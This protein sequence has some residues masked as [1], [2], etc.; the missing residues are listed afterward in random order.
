MS[1]PRRVPAPRPP[2]DAC[3]GLGGSS[4]RS[5]P[6]C[7]P[8]WWRN[9]GVPTDGSRHA[10]ARSSSRCSP[11]RPQ[12]DTDSLRRSALPASPSPSRGA[13]QTRHWRAAPCSSARGCPS[14]CST[15][16][17]AM[18]P[19]A[20]SSATPK[21]PP[22]DTS[23][24]TATGQTRHRRRRAKHR[25]P[26]GRRTVDLDTP[27]PPVA[28]ASLLAMDAEDSH[29][30]RGA[31]AVTLA[32]APAPA[33]GAGSTSVCVR[34]DHATSRSGASVHSGLKP[35]PAWRA[36]RGRCDP[37]SVARP[38]RGSS[39]TAV[40]L[41]PCRRARPARRGHRSTPSGCARRARR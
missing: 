9:L 26:M 38:P 16:C 35:G 36:L 20:T 6:P 32:L 40:A 33:A 21:R 15:S 17:F 34:D 1:E 28:R 23:T 18:G 37:R 7:S 13:E 25:S 4:R 39:R 3:R 27:I 10:R 31:E 12:C 11:P 29:Q 5:T 30:R 41:P 8:L 2:R 19:P 22:A 24:T 14:S